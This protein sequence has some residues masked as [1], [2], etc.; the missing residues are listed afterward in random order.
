M[1][2]PTSFTLMPGESRGAGRGGSH[3]EKIE[4]IKRDFRA[5]TRR[6]PFSDE[7][8]GKHGLGPLEDRLCQVR[9]LLLL[10]CDWRADYVLDGLRLALVS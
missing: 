5:S 7:K 3:W 6:T 9:S 2:L 1:Q 10:C 8:E 4:D